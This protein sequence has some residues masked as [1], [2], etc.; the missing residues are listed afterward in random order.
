[1]AMLGRSIRDRDGLPTLTP[2][3]HG[4]DLRGRMLHCIGQGSPA[5]GLAVDGPVA[6]SCRRGTPRR[7]SPGHQ[8]VHPAGGRLA[9]PRRARPVR[10]PAGLPDLRLQTQ[11]RTM[12]TR[13]GRAKAPSQHDCRP[14]C[15]NAVRTDGHAHDLRERASRTSQ[16]AAH[17]PD[18][19]P[20]GSAPPQGASS[21]AGPSPPAAP[22]P[23]SPWLPMPTCTA[24]P[25][26]N[27]TPT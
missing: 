7:G 18:P 26:S 17:A 1:M 21:Q 10:Q 27:G 4:A 2:S 3:R 14:G 16:L 6:N 15:G 5:V 22:S 25:C 24:W 13:P 12:R 8:E 20:I 11:H 19:S 9:R 23:S